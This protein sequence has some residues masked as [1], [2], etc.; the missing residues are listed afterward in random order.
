MSNEGVISIEN[1]SSQS[2]NNI[3]F[4]KLNETISDIDCEVRK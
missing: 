1:M 2:S 3:F 4:F